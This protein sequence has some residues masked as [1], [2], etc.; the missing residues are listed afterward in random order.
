MG[1]EGAKKQKRGCSGRLPTRSKKVVSPG[2]KKTLVDMQ[3]GQN[4]GG[5]ALKTPAGTKANRAEKKGEVGGK[6]IGKDALGESNIMERQ[7]AAGDSG[8]T[9]GRASLLPR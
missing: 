8:G 5:T 9:G 7:K 1:R 6:P 2:K 4:L 3:K